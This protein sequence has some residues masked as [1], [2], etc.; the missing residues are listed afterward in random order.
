MLTLD[1]VQLQYGDH[2][3]LTGLSADFPSGEI[4][5]IVGMNGSG[6]TSLLRAI[7]GSVPFQGG[8]IL[9]NDVP[10]HRRMVGFLE[11]QN[12]FYPRITGGEYLELFLS[13][14]P[15]F[16]LDGWNALFDLP[17]DH[18]VDGYST[19]MKKKLAFMG[20]LALDRPILILDE[21]FNGLDL[22]SNEALQQILPKLKR[23]DR[24]ILITS[25]IKDTLISI[26]HRIHLLRGGVFESSFTSSEFQQMGTL[27]DQRRIDQIDELL[28]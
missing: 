22:E 15:D 19:G 23:P 28:G 12:Y 24:L 6:K 20:L 1:Q 5:G 27:L 3:V 14:Y 4:H 18:L 9:W 17:L 2:A 21:P 13:S 16:D 10:T 26:C 7:H 25:H 8:Q 11:T